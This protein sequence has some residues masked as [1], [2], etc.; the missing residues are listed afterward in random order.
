MTIPVQNQMLQPT[1]LHFPLSLSHFALDLYK[2]VHFSSNTHLSLALND[3]ALLLFGSL[4][5]HTLTCVT[6]RQAESSS[7]WWTVASFFCKY[8]L[9]I[10]D[11]LRTTK[12]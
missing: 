9:C 12:R 6:P 11:R 10:F 4:D 8:N 1:F 7:F 5:N 2:P 3:F